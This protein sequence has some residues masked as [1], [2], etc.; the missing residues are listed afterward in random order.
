MNLLI[1]SSA[2]RLDVIT[3]FKEAFKSQNVSGEVV[4]CD[5][6]YN[7]PSLQVADKSYVVPE[8]NDQM[9]VEA[10]LHICKKEAIKSVFPL[11]DLEIHLLAENKNRFH[12]I[13]TQLLVPDAAV[14]RKVRD[15]AAY[16]D[17]LTFSNVR[18]PKTFIS[19]NEVHEALT[20]GE[21]SYPLVLKPR[22][23]SASFGILF[24]R[25]SDD[26]YYA[27]RYVKEEV[28]QSPLGKEYNIPPEQAVVIQE[29][30]DGEKYSVDVIN[31]LHGNYL[32]T[33]VRKQLAMRAGDVDRCITV[34]DRKLEL[35]GEK[36]GTTLQHRGYLNT[37]VYVDEQGP[38]VIDIN[39]R[40]GGGYSF[41][42]MSG[43]DI[44]AAITALLSGGPI[45]PEWLTH[46]HQKEFARYDAVT[47]INR[48]NDKSATN[49]QALS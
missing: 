29:V 43:A 34:R 44:P 12:R 6:Q 47:E 45:Q 26:L 38:C 16:S 49:I 46:D 22:N 48:T 20:N 1:T 5:S 42:H 31:D 32:T 9:Y 7:A 11:N 3:F 10:L 24:A 25:N 15:K 19:M 35:L 28:L 27:Y 36:I 13:G 33:L 2:R 8:Y 14:V 40:M 41:S 4:V 23:G 21:I 37:D 39:P 30:V 17:L 18:T